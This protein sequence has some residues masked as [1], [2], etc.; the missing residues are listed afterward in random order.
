MKIFALHKGYSTDYCTREAERPLCA[1]E[2]HD[3]GFV[4]MGDVN[5]SN[6]KRRALEADSSE[7]VA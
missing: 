6:V 5:T 7:W 1:E 3:T 2:P 4:G